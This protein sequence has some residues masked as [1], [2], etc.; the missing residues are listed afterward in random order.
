MLDF[1]KE[2]IKNMFI[3]TCL[4]QLLLFYRDHKDIFVS[5]STQKEKREI[6]KKLYNILE[7][8]SKP[9]L[10][11]EMK[12]TIVNG[13]LVHRGISASSKEKL[14]SYI[15]EFISGEVFYGGR[16]SIYGTG[17]YTVVGEDRDVACKYATNGDTNDIGI[18]ITSVLKD[19]A[20]I[21]SSE[22]LRE[23]KDIVLERL[24]KAY[25]NMDNYLNILEDDGAFAAILGY[26]AIYVKEKEYMVILNRSKLIV[27][28]NQIRHD[29]NRIDGEKS[30]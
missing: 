21:I 13:P 29:L 18:V 6:I 20:E 25:N 7:Y 4:K 5:F 12:P 23:I 17:I 15:K 27:Y 16:A 30:R 3:D 28:D 2:D 1:S 8:D 14:I 19:D 24:K 9:Q 11:T 10:N 26:D 22:D